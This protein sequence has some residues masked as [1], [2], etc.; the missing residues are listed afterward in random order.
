MSSE[1]KAPSS[2]RWVLRRRGKDI[3][4]PTLEALREWAANGRVKDNDFVYDPRT[5]RW[6]SAH[7][8]ADLAGVL[9]APP[10]EPTIVGIVGL[11]FGMGF[12]FFGWSSGR[13]LYAVLGAG[14]IGAGL[15]TQRAMRRRLTAKS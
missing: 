15:L 2:D 6:A 8:M 3:E 1:P 11:L 7:Q 12:F 14:F 5:R 10:K 13:W 9:K 4:I